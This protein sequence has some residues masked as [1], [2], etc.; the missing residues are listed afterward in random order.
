[1]TTC[2]RRNGAHRRRALTREAAGPGQESARKARQDG[3]VRIADHV[4]DPGLVIQEVEDLGTGEAAVEAHED[5]GLR[6]GVAQLGHQAPQDTQDAA[7]V[8]GVAGTQDRGEQ[9]LLGLMVEAEEPE[10]RQVAAGVV[11]AV[12]EAQLLCTVGGIVGG[13]EVHDHPAATTTQPQAM[14]VD[15]EPGDDLAHAVEVRGT[16]AVLEAREGWLGCQGEAVDG[17]ASE[18]QL[19]N[20]VMGKTRGVVGIGVT[21]GEAEDPLGEQL[22]DLVVDL[23]GLPVIGETA[24]E[25]LGQAELFIDS[26]QQHGAPVGAGVGKIEPSGERAAKKLWKE[27]ALCRSLGGHQKASVVCGK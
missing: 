24:C 18:E 25:F 6:E 9:V 8:G 22:P 11:V 10:Q 15:D 14:P 3:V 16:D 4:V 1:V 19:V 26:L 2:G 21:A 17:I 7:L 27:N 13:V 12:E 23:S 20:G 5:A